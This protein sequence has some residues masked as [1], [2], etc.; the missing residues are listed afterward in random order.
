MNKGEN[1]FCWHFSNVEVLMITLT[2]ILHFKLFNVRNIV[3]ICQ[4]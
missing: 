2:L 3:Y 1:Y 4:A